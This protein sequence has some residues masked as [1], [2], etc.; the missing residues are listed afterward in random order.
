MHGTPV[1]E[2]SGAPDPPSGYDFHKRCPYAVE[3]RGSEVPALLP[4][5]DVTVA[6]HSAAELNVWRALRALTLSVALGIIGRRLPGHAR[7]GRPR[8]RPR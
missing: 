3:R 7:T 6:C 2:I 4:Q 1:A 5:G 8:Q